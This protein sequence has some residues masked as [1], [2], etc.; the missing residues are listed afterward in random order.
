[1]H[2]LMRNFNTDPESS[3][4]IARSLI[5]KGSNLKALNGSSLTPLHIALYYA[6][7]EA[8][9]FALHHNS[10]LRKS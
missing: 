3:A 2:V 6:Q 7:N 9:K 5:R 1:M 10:K 4:K 8:V